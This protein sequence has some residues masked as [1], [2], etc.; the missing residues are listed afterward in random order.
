VKNLYKLNVD[1]CVSLRKKAVKVK[2]RDVGELWHRRLGHLHHGSLKI[3]QHIT[4]G[5]PIRALEQKNACKGCTFG[6]Y[7]KSSFNDRDSKVHAIL[8]RIHSDV[9]GIF[10][11][12]SMANHG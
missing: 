3:M 12:T 9:Y 11:T 4:T 1:E 7:T 2:S 5:L 8:E 10:S 6:K